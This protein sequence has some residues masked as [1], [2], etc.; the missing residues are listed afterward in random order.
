MSNARLFVGNLPYRAEESELNEY[1][2]QAGVVSSVQLMFDR[3]TGRSRGFGFIEYTT[4]DDANKAV[5]MFNNQDFQGRNLT[6][7]IA[8]PRESRGPQGRDR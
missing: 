4:P 2:S 3:D 5:E 6:V 8:R 7:N 1:F